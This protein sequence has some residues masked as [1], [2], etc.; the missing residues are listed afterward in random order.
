[1]IG[2]V[3]TRARAAAWRP[4]AVTVQLAVFVAAV[5]ARVAV[6]LRHGGLHG[7]YGYDAGVYFAASDA[8]THGRLPYRDFVLLHPPGL[9]LMLSP[10]AALTRVASDET[11]FTVAVLAFTVL[12][13]INAMLVLRVVRRLG[14]GLRAAA[15]AGAFYALWFGSIGSEYLIKLEPAGNLLFLLG[16]LAALRARAGRSVRWSLVAG[17]ALGATVSVKIWW[18]V[19]FALAVV[20]LGRRTRSLRQVGAALAGAALV[21]LAVDGPFFVA[22]PRA[23]WSAVVQD[24]VSRGT[25]DSSP[26]QR[27]TDLSSLPRL[28]GSIAPPGTVVVGVAVLLLAAWLSWRA[29]GVAAARPA[30]L[31]LVAQTAVLL[32]APSW[33]P[34]YADFLAVAAAITCGAAV[35]RP[36]A[37]RARRVPVALAPPGW[38]VL[39]VA[40]AITVPA[41]VTGSVGV[42]AFH[43]AAALT[44]DTRS[45]RCVV[46]DSPMGQIELDALTRG[47]R[48]GCRNWIDVT[49]RT[50]GPD[51]SAHH[52]TRNRRWQRDLRRYLR[53]GG[54][55]LIVRG[56]G[57]GLSRATRRAISDG[58]VLARAG[59]HT[60]FRVRA[61]RHVPAQ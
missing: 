43:G 9:M 57:T 51:R 48:H 36:P 31:L 40:T 41:L 35:A 17:V 18:I 21:T 53:S 4:G 33:F 5:G 10:F 7:D 24:Q 39:A 61:A 22:A 50:Y 56:S 25:V 55:V 46:S 47:L 54:A 37:P 12:G 32:A 6:V 13:G 60:V 1:M 59:G 23:M 20:W 44:R 38:V 3:P 42:P 28:T 16:L 2:A 27:L 58:G 15:A 11:A 52:R 29:W 30:V 34:Y 14:L 8:F 26:W 45:V 19:P 49:G